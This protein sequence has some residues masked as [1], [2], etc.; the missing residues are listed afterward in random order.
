MNPRSP[1]AVRGVGGGQLGAPWEL[2]WVLPLISLEPAV[3]G[4]QAVCCHRVIWTNGSLFLN[5]N[6]RGRNVRPRLTHLEPPQRCPGLLAQQQDGRGHGTWLGARPCSAMPFCLPCRPSDEN[7]PHVK[8]D[9]YVNNL[10]E[11]VDI[12]LQQL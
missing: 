4:S 7:H 5:L 1:P 11:A 8:P 9:A 2:R 12:L 6:R 3:G 10:A